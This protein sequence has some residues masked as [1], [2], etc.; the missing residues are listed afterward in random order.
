MVIINSINVDYIVYIL[1]RLPLISQY[2][3]SWYT[4]RVSTRLVQQVL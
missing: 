4:K 3:S 1:T 2:L